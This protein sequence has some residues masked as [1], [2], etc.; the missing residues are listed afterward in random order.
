MEHHV[1]KC[2]KIMHSKEVYYDAI[3]AS[4]LN[5]V[6]IFSIPQSNQKSNTFAATM[7][8]AKPRNLIGS[9]GIAEFGPKY[10]QVFRVRL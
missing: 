10:D 5:L 4:N 2:R 6:G 3:T 8:T 1:S 7:V 9:L